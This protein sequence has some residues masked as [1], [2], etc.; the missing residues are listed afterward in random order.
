[1]TLPHTIFPPA[2]QGKAGTIFLVEQEWA[3]M[4]ASLDG[5]SAEQLTHPGLTGEWSILEMAIHLG[6]WFRAGTDS[7]KILARGD[8]LSVDYN[9]YDAWNARFI[10]E[11]RG[12]DAAQ[13]VEQMRANYAVFLALIRDLAPGDLERHAIADTIE[14]ES[15]GHFGEHYYDV[16][17][18]RGANGWLPAPPELATM[19]ATKREALT[20]LWVE[21]DTFYGA[22]LGLSDEQLA[23]PGADGPWAIRDTIAHLAA[24]QRAAVN[25]VPRILAGQPTAADLEVVDDFNAR[26]VERAGT[27][28]LDAL[29]TEYHSANNHF[30]SY[31]NTLV[32]GAFAPGSP[33]RFWLVSPH[34]ADHYPAIWAW[35]RAQG[36]R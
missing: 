3:R 20:A 36:A 29:F 14:G 17:R 33:A 9:D 34:P 28:S 8:R 18:F 5:L 27:L 10:E 35:R 1:M 19:P 23:A 26:A 4:S 15:W 2:P 32:D 16:W 24:W 30:F 22:M 25:E 11:G 12:L 31:A 6:G 13:A 21:Y 7:I